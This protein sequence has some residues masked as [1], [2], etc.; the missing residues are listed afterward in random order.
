LGLYVRF[1]LTILW[2]FRWAVAIFWALVLGGGLLLYWAYHDRRLDFVEACYA[3]F[4]MVFLE[5][6][7]DFPKERA[8]QPMFF[9]VPIIGLG[10]VADSVVRLGFLIFSQRNRS[11]EWQQMMASLEREHTIVVGLGKV[12]YQIAKG[13]LALGESV[14]VI[15]RPEAV[16]TLIDE[17]QAQQVPI[18]RGDGRAARTLELA[19]ITHAKAVVLSSSDDL[20]NLDAGLTARD[21]NAHA[22]VVLRLFDESLAEKV[23][24]AFAMPAI[25]TAHVA[26]PAFVA[27][28]TGRRLYQDFELA[29]RHLHLIDLT[30]ASGGGLDG[31]SVGYVQE[32]LGVNIVMYHHEAVVNVNPQHDLGLAAGDELLVIGTLGE[33]M[34]LEEVNRRN[35]AG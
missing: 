32:N 16:S 8:L 21:L 4:L 2:T 23:Q 24:G 26:A 18:V 5:P 31:R 22:R 19:G 27:A 15:E 7:L 11:P 34:H 28:A 30:I 29:G 3:V 12:G 17:I 35:G 33:L 25:S 9:L 14:V 13:L 6:Y 20:T 1:V 10:A